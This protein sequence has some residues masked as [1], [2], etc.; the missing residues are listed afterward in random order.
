MYNRTWHSQISHKLE[1]EDETKELKGLYTLILQVELVLYL[2]ERLRMEQALRVPWFLLSGF[3]PPPFTTLFTEE[4]RR[5][6][7]RARIYSPYSGRF[8]WE[9]DL[10]RYMKVAATWRAYS[11]RQG[12]IARTGNQAERFAV[13]EHTLTTPIPERLHHQRMATVGDHVMFEVYRRNGVKKSVELDIAPDVAKVGNIPVPWLT[14]PRKREESIVL[15]HSTLVDLARQM[16]SLEQRSLQ[17]RG[18]NDPGTDWVTLAQNLHFRKREGD[19]SLG[20]VNAVPIALKGYVHLAGTISVGK[21]TLMKL[22]AFQATQQHWRVTLIVG[23][24]MT[25]LELTDFFD[26]LLCGE[27]DPPVA[28]PLL[29][30]TTLNKNLARLSN[31]ASYKKH[32]HHRALRYLHIAC[33]LLNE[34]PSTVPEAFPLGQEPCQKLILVPPRE[35][36]E[37]DTADGTNQQPHR[38]VLLTCP[39]FPLCPM[40][41]AYRDL[42][43]APIWI[44]TPGALGSMTVPAQLDSRRIKLWEL[45]YDQSPLV[46][47]DEADAIQNWFDR[48][49]APEIILINKDGILDRMDPQVS[50]D[51]VVRRVLEPECYRWVLAERQATAVTATLL[52]QLEYYW[53]LARW[54][55]QTCFTAYSLFFHLACLFSGIQEPKVT[56]EFDL[57]DD[58]DDQENTIFPK[59]RNVNIHN[60]KFNTIMGWFYRVMESDPQKVPAPARAGKKDPVQQTPSDTRTYSGARILP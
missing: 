7:A 25:A 33:L 60:K 21:T 49:C 56:F 45:I 37:L 29:G 3:S 44:T 58:E 14:E 1:R 20:E 18:E 55:H 48:V 12:K 53:F 54:V 36:H 6:L 28:V 17:A 39:L 31:A 16:A 42:F 30:K 19:G 24:V 50:T 35:E 9:T 8:R 22:I 40:Q 43:Q 13:F 51:W 59:K 2:L 46:C 57:D 32:R 47:F 27:D 5:L 41:Q 10:Q 34:W 15:E 23:D 26:S 38:R 11:V 52:T 4:E